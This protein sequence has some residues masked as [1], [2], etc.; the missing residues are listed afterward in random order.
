LDTAGGVEQYSLDVDDK[1]GNKH[2]IT[3]ISREDVAALSIAALSVANGQNVSFDC[4]TREVANGE[5]PSSA[6][7]ALTTF[8][9]QSKTAKYAH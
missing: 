2:E 1:L 8:L 7:E 4:I 3:R 6:E 9:E 5:T